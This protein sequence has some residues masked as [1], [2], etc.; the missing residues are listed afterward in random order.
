MRRITMLLTLGAC[1]AI[2]GCDVPGLAA[3]R[4]ANPPGT[5]AY[6]DCWRA[7]LQRQDEDAN[8][9]RFLNFRGKD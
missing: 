2:T 6:Q 5:P 7:E 4:Q 1:A 9:Q 3:C 8:R